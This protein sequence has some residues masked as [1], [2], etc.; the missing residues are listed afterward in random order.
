MMKTALAAALIVGGASAANA[1]KK[2]YTF[3]TADGSPYCDGAELTESSGVAVGVHLGV[4]CTEGDYAGGL[5]GTQIP[6]GAGK[7]Y[8]MVTNEY[9]IGTGYI[10][11]FTLNQAKLTWTLWLESTSGG[12]TFEEINAGELLKGKVTDRYGKF[13]NVPAAL[14]HISTH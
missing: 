6:V 7:Q 10:E 5:E 12:L 14:G 13:R 3:G 1:A 2:I 9:S 11:Y 8:T 4:Q